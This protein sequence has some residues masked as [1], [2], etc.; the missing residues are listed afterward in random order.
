MHRLAAQVSTLTAATSDKVATKSE[1]L[2]KEKEAGAVTIEH[3][4]WIIV[5]I[6]LVGAVAAIVNSYVTSKAGEIR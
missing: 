5:F 3:V 2:K 6:A 4:L 1:A